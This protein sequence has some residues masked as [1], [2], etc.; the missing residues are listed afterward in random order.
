MPLYSSN[1]ACRI[2]GFM[3]LT[4]YS[5]PQVGV[6]WSESRLITPCYS[7]PVLYSPVSVLSCPG[8]TCS[9]MVSIEQWYS[10]RVDHSRNPQRYSVRLLTVQLAPSFSW[11]VI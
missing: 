9:P 3:S 4:P 2:Y 8:K 10:D 6:K 5:Q 1:L 11:V 7:F